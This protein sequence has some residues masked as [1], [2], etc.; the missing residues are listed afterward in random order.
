[1]QRCEEVVN[2]CYI[3]LRENRSSV[4][5]INQELACVLKVKIDGCLDSSGERC[6]YLIS[7]QNENYFIELKGKNIL[8]A[9]QQIISSINDHNKRYGD[10]TCV[11]VIS[12]TRVPAVT[13][14]QKAYLT[15]R[16]NCQ[17]LAAQYHLSSSGVTIYI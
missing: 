15:A 10:K 5:F 16:R 17:V 4:K 3:V 1:M 8:K 13:S 11:A 2:E 7:T 6:D 12:A 9:L 14:F